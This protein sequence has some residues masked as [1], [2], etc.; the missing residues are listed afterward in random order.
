MR[1]ATW[2]AAVAAALVVAACSSTPT[3]PGASTAPPQV[4]STTDMEPSESYEDYSLRLFDWYDQRE[5]LIR[6]CMAAAGYDYYQEYVSSAERD[7][8]TDSQAADIEATGPQRLIPLELLIPR[9]EWRRVYEIVGYGSFFSEA[10]V[11]AA[12]ASV[13]SDPGVSGDSASSSPADALAVAATPGQEQNRQYLL[14]LPG[15]DRETYMVVLYG[16][17]EDDPGIV[18]EGCFSEAEGEVGELPPRLNFD[19]ERHLE[20]EDRVLALVE[21]RPEMVDAKGGYAGCM[22]SEGYDVTDPEDAY[23]WFGAFANTQIDQLAEAGVDLAPLWE[24]GDWSAVLPADRLLE[25]QQQ[26]IDFALLDWDCGMVI[27]EIR[28]EVTAEVERE[29]LLNE[30]RDVAVD[31]GIDLEE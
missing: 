14:S 17:S 9:D 1:R 12:E 6:E 7:A 22:A 25:L 31:L 10:E 28:A 8:L 18:V 3:Q 4:S 16:T 11:A 19:L 26:E 27:W 30:Y 20:A 23:A 5:D 13:R 21:V 29:V 2:G 15:A 24:S